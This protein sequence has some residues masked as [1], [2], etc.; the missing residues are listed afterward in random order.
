MSQKAISVFI[1]YSTQD[2]KHKDRLKVALE[3]LERNG[4]LKS[5]DESDI[6][7]GSHKEESMLNKIN[8]ADLLLFL[9][10]PDYLAS[11]EA[12]DLEV[13]KAMER[14]ENPGDEVRIVPIVTRFCEWKETDFKAFQVLPRN[15]KP[16]SSWNDPDEVYLHITTELK[17][18]V[19]GEEE[20][21]S[22]GSS[23]HDEAP[24]SGNPVQQAKMLIA[25]GEAKKALKIL[26]DHTKSEDEDLHNQL[27]LQSGRLNA[28]D[29][30]LRMGVLT[31][32]DA[33]IE[34]SRINYAL[35][36][37]IEDMD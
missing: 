32:Q 37:I 26:L 6:D 21:T 4:Y 11:D 18:I 33:N 10:S 19:K 36:S 1:S 12:F 17:K 2:K 23:T 7:I 3:P 25:E 27:I 29:K 15:S 16:I 13:K 30:R 5:W 34:Q 8:E 20:A 31:T 14:H 35:L 28:L 22:N 24:A 9:L